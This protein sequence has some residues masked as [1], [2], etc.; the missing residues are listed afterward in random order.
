VQ[1][2]NAHGISISVVNITG[3][4]AT[5]NIST[6]FRKNPG[7]TEFGPLTCQDGY[8]WRAADDL[9]YVCV[10]PAARQEVADENA[11][12]AEHAHGSHCD[13]GYVSRAAFPHDKVCVTPAQRASVRADNAQRTD[14]LMKQSAFL[15]P[16]N[17][18]LS[19]RRLS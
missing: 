18:G 11:S 9:D 2:L 13:S 6:N 14:R 16:P 5:V 4:Q 15:P 1:S 17:S 19:D 8:V 12:A 7:W 10:T 3:N